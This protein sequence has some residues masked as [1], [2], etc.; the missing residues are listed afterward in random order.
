MRRSHA[1]S[2][3]RLSGGTSPR[4]VNAAAMAEGSIQVVQAPI[5]SCLTVPKAKFCPPRVANPAAFAA[6]S[7]QARRRRGTLGARKRLRTGPL[8]LAAKRPAPS[9]SVT[10]DDGAD[11]P[12]PAVEAPELPKAEP[13]AAKP[14]SAAEGYDPVVLWV[15]EEAGGIAAWDEEAEA[16][17]ADGGIPVA[18]PGSVVVDACVGRFLRPH[19]REGLRFLWDCVSGVRVTQTGPGVLGLGKSGK[20]GDGADSDSSSDTDATADATTTTARRAGRGRG[21]PAKGGGR[22]GGHSSSAAAAAAA[23]GA[24]PV[25][26]SSRRRRVAR[27]PTPSDDDEEDTATSSSED[28]NGDGSADE[29]ESGGGR[30]GANAAGGGDGDGDGD[31]GGDGDGDATEDE[32]DEEEEEEEEEAGAG[33]SSGSDPD[34]DDGDTDAGEDD[35]GDAP[36]SAPRAAFK[37][38]AATSGGGGSSSSSSSSSGGG[39]GV[40]G[41]AAPLAGCILADDMG[42]GKT[43]QSVTLLWTCLQQGPNGSPLA[44]RAIVVTPTSLVANWSQEIRKWLGDRCPHIALSEACRSKVTAGISEFLAPRG[45]RLLILSYET[46]R[47]HAK[48]LTGPA[49]A[50]A[51]ELLIC[52]EAHRL[53]NDE[54]QT[55]RALSGLATLRRVLLSGTPIQNNLD[56]FYAMANFCNPGVL[57]TPKQ[58]HRHFESPILEARE[59][60]ASDA[61]VARSAVATEALSA[62]VNQF[63]LRRTNALLSD[64]LPPKLVQ[65]VV[66]PLSPLQRQMYEA[67]LAT[68][69]VQSILRAAAARAAAADEAAAAAAASKRGNRDDGS[70]DDDDDD[71]GGD[72][73]NDGSDDDDDDGGGG[74]GGALSEAEEVDEE[75]AAAIAA[76]AGSSGRKAT[77]ALPVINTLRKICNH[78]SIALQP[79][80]DS[81]AAGVTSA[82]RDTMLAVC[83]V[84]DALRAAASGYGLSRR[85]GGGV[86]ASLGGKVSLLA[87]MLELMRAR[88][89]ERIVIVSVT[90]QTLDLVGQLCQER[91]FPVIRLDGSIGAG[92]RQQLVDRFNDPSRD[93]FVFLLSSKAGGCGLNL[94]G[95]SRLVLL[96]CDWNPAVDKQAAARVWR[97]GQKRRVFVYRFLARGTL[98]EKIFQRQLSKE[99]LHTIVVEERAEAVSIASEALRDLF[100]YDAH[101]ES[102]THRAIRCSWQDHPGG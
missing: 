61:A 79:A 66:C 22:R 67:V 20:S 35:G 98:E 81:R 47:M 28:E 82:L 64:H 96:D 77:G 56:E 73:N 51:C 3:R 87:S 34:D 70:D 30:R 76:A 17:R 84:P 40:G 101:V 46:F 92:K 33:G 29:V 45:P 15:P 83:D 57:G 8:L 68:D 31:G 36:P 71:D 23:A 59:P 43:L 75:T 88:G 37:P 93:E 65:V 19:Q 44:R 95:A 39:S 41:A 80:G 10:S 99:G 91:G 2:Q 9:P 53:K 90:T 21:R 63:V 85:R 74:G 55:A 102:D 50:S 12:S 72:D 16:V 54:T 49:A 13:A 48:R 7:Q 24:S 38:P 58:F 1:P 6:M 5:L 25:R 100:Q 78:P 4:S 18:P 86:D 26:R 11:A 89:T 69:A 97:D 52:D 62:V 94:V 42:L 32:D 14:S 60:G 27:P